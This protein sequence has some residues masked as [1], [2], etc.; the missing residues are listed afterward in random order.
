MPRRP[1]AGRKPK[2][3]TAGVPFSLR[4]APDLRKE[5]ARSA[6]RRRRPLS[7]EIISRLR[8]SLDKE[9]ESDPALRALCYLFSEIVGKVK[10][11]APPFEEKEWYRDPFL[12]TAFKIGVAKL[13]D[14]RTPPGEVK[15]PLRA[16]NPDGTVH[17]WF[18]TP[19]ATA[20]MAVDYVLLQLYQSLTPDK[21]PTTARQ[22]HES[23]KYADEVEDHLYSMFR[24]RRDLG[25]D[26]PEEMKQ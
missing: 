20:K 5:L 12:F 19:E 26:Q 8:L 2:G 23:S 14:E 25:I 13:L 4:L 17:E 3:T 9:R 21:M 24:A 1:N 10:W 22:I 18:Q 15:P 7:E 16:R 11:G 6:K